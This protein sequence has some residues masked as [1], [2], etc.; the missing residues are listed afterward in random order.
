VPAL[1]GRVKRPKN[2]LDRARRDTRAVVF[3]TRG[4]VLTVREHLDPNFRP[5]AAF[6]SV[7]R[8]EEQIQDDLTQAVAATDRKAR[9]V[10][11]LRQ[12]DASAPRCGKA[13]DSDSCTTVTR[14]THSG[15]GSRRDTS[16]NC[17]TVSRIRATAV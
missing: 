12:R 16:D 5:R 3:A 4:H 17:S 13:I 7:A 14:S 10:E 15:D 6:A 11:L 8:V 9:S 2:V 1:L